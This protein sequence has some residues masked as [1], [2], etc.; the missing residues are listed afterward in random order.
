MTPRRAG[1]VTGREEWPSRG[2]KKVVTGEKGGETT[3]C[4][5]VEENSEVSEYLEQTHYMFF[6][7]EIWLKNYPAFSVPDFLLAKDRER[8]LLFKLRIR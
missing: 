2:E 8:E 1:T 3:R 7:I 5:E 4:G 6:R